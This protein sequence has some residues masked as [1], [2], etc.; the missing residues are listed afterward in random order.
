MHEHVAAAVRVAGD[1]V[2]RERQ[3]RDA[4]AVARED[5]SGA[6]IVLLA[7]GAEREQ[8]EAG[9]SAASGPARL[10]LGGA[11]PGRALRRGR[12]RSLERDAPSWR[13]GCGGR[14]RSGSRSS[15]RPRASRRRPWSRPK[16]RPRAGLALSR[17]APVEYQGGPDPEQRAAP[18]TAAPESVP[19]RL[20]ALRQVPYMGVIAVIAEAARLGYSNG[21]GRRSRRE[22]RGTPGARSS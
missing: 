22:R 17:R 9:S 10:R 19:S 5:G 1:E 2:A 11:L 16:C 7:A 15:R 21:S 3:A 6:G 8:L 13:E 4:P 18:M 12:G 14:S 20:G